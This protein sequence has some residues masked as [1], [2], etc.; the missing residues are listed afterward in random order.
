MATTPDSTNRNLEP[1]IGTKDEAK[2]GVPAEDEGLAER[3]ITPEPTD[4]QRKD[5]FSSTEISLG[6]TLQ[7]LRFIDNA[8][9]LES[10][11][12]EKVKAYLDELL[13]GLQKRYGPGSTEFAA[14]HPCSTAECLK[15][16]A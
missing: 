8:E 13:D 4:E 1:Y 9:I 11:E 3:F 16:A 12:R 10:G 5:K 6:K 15:V 7:W 14:E 2:W